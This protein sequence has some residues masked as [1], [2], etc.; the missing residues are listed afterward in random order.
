MTVNVDKLSQKHVQ[1]SVQ[2]CH[3]S[4]LDQSLLNRVALI[5]HLMSA[6]YFLLWKCER[7]KDLM[8]QPSDFPPWYHV[9]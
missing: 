7:E 3:Q 9:L 5:I 8:G 1:Q 4:L 6:F 2:P